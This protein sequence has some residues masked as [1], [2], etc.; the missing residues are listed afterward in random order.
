MAERET[1]IHRY[2]RVFGSDDGQIVL[3]SILSQGGWLMSTFS[4]SE[5][6]MAYNCGKRDLALGILNSLSLT[7]K[8]IQEIAQ[9]MN[10]EGIDEVV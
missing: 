7:E 8:Q 6:R 10:R 2:R 4:E 5:L 1:E 3:R 9:R